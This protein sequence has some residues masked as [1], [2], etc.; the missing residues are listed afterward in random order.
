MTIRVQDMSQ[1]VCVFDVD[2]QLQLQWYNNIP[3]NLCHYVMYVPIS[4]NG[5]SVEGSFLDSGTGIFSSCLSMKVDCR[6]QL[7]MG[8]IARR[9]N[10]VDK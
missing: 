10:R 5:T 9:H 8:L 7:Y 2:G 4:R 1:A 6:T 3:G